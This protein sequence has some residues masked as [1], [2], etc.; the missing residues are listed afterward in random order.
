[1]FYMIF[2]IDVQNGFIGRVG[3]FHVFFGVVCRIRIKLG[4]VR[5]GIRIVLFVRRIGVMG[6][7]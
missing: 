2:I 5:G 3:L 6:L 7:I 4:W 1:M